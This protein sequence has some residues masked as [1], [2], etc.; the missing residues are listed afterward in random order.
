LV[1]IYPP[2]IGGLARMKISVKQVDSLQEFSNLIL[3]PHIIICNA[4]VGNLHL[5]LFVF[6]ENLPIHQTQSSSSGSVSGAQALVAPF[7]VGIL[8]PSIFRGFRSQ[9]TLQ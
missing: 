4:K 2:L 6:N 5:M 3:Q 8:M 7:I 1:Q 9:H